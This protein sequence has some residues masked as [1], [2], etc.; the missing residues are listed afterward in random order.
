MTED[1]IDQGFNF[2]EKY[3]PRSHSLQHPAAVDLKAAGFLSTGFELQLEN[4]NCVVQ[5]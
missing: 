2:I 1:D 3:G 4:R 5:V